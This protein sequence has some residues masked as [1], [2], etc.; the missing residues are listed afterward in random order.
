MK[1]ECD[2][3]ALAVEV[4]DL[5]RSHGLTIGTV[6]SCTGGLVAGALT[7]IPGSSD[8]VMAGLVTYSNAAKSSLA[9]VPPG[10]I[11]QYG[12][13]S[14]DVARAMATGGRERL[15]VDLCVAITGI[16]GPG[17]G[18]AEKPVGLVWF[19]VAS[20]EDVRSRR[21]MFGGPG[22]DAIRMESVALALHMLKDAAIGPQRV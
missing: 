14:E 8:V 12:A 10:L 1:P 18:S 16:A 9:N 5:C 6:E 13:V 4:L 2:I 21:A 19:A 20:A 7:G 11:E 22:R 3:S 15:R 17:G